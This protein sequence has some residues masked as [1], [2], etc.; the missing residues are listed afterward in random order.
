VTAVAF[1]G[2]SGGGV[3]LKDDGTY[4]GMLTQGVMRL[5]GF[6][7]IVPVRRMHAWAKEAKIEWAL[8]TSVP[9]PTMEEINAIAVEDVGILESD[10]L[11]FPAVC[12]R[13]LDDY[14]IG[15][16]LMQVYSCLQSLVEPASVKK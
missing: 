5:Q 6:N 8:D 11:M 13:R 3:Y 14:D 9:I 7:F 16:W 12:S 2:S 15:Q 1:P 4:V 10:S